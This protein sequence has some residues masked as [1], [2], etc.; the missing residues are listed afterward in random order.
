[1]SSPSGSSP[2]AAGRKPG[3]PTCWPIGRPAE[4][5]AGPGFAPGRQPHA[6]RPRRAARGGL[7]PPPARDGRRP[8][9]IRRCR[10]PPPAASGRSTPPATRPG[11]GGGPGGSRG[12]GATGAARADPFSTDF[13]GWVLPTFQGGF[14]RL[15]RVGLAPDYRLSRVGFTDF[16]GW[17]RDRK[18]YHYWTYGFHTSEPW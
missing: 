2:A 16:P 11:R 13:P 7:R 14:Y 12:F 10:P 15:S 8:G 3:S 4:P 9:P 5:R 6:R 18:W 17:V 1:M